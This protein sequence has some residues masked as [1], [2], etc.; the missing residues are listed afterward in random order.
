VWGALMRRVR[1]RLWLGAVL[2]GCALSGATA[3]VGGAWLGGSIVGAT[4]TTVTITS[5]G[6]AGGNFFCYSPASITVANGTTVTWSNHSGVPHTVTRCS[7]PACGTGGGTGTDSSFT[8]G[9]VASA[10]G[11]TFSHTFHGSGTYVYYCMIH[12][13]AAMHGTVIVTGVPAAPTG[14]SAM[15]RN[16][17]A[18]VHW[19]APAANGSQITNYTVTPYIGMAP[20][21]PHTFPATSTTETVTGLSNAT[22]YTFKVAATNGSGT[23]PQSAASTPITVGAPTAPTGVHATPRPTSTTTGPLTVSFTAG[24]NNGSA[25]TGY[26]ATCKSTNAGVTGTHLGTASPIIVSGLTTAKTYTC[27]VTA[28]NARGTGPPSAPSTPVIIGAPAAPTAVTAVKVASGQLKVSFTP[29]A[30]N[31]SAIT[32]YTATCKSTNAGVTGTHP[33]TGSPIIVSGLT[34]A[35]TYTCTVT[36]KNARGA[37]PPSAPS[38]MVTA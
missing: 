34:T 21:T 29:G 13:Y 12:G 31:G 18:V 38:T 8:N 25:I 1:P 30:N 4:T 32:G 3:F 33:G 36:A 5:T 7:I 26:T 20:Q 16:A 14:V 6:C 17:S 11:S 28:K 22:A 23:G 10:N 35:K 9:N 2:A 37:G 15:P 27:T 24:A 19:T